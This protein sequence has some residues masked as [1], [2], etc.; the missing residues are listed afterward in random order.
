MLICPDCGVAALTRKAVLTG[1]IRGPFECPECGATVQADLPRWLGLV[2]LGVPTLQL[3]VSNV[4]RNASTLLLV[5]VF[6]LLTGLA[7]GLSLWL[8]E[9]DRQV[10]RPLPRSAARRRP[11]GPQLPSWMR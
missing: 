2:A 9:F 1:L 6:V 4:F 8:L 3:A 5:V 7:V 10:T 11:A